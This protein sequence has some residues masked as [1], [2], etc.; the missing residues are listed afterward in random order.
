MEIPK[1]SDIET[2]EEL[3]KLCEREMDTIR[4]QN[5]LIRDMKRGE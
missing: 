3:E 5:A 2:W 1:K 4:L